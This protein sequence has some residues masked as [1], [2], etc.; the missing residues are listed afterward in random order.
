[1]KEDIYDPHCQGHPRSLLK[2]N[3]AC[4]W[5]D[6]D[7]TKDKLCTDKTSFEFTRFVKT[8]NKL[9]VASNP[10]IY[11]KHKLYV[12]RSEPGSLGLSAL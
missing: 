12:Q 3:L 6:D 8:S 1:M 5:K 7:K 10:V 2:H 9:I 4:P 11:L